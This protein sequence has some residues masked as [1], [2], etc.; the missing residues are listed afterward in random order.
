MRVLAEVE[1]RIPE[2]RGMLRMVAQM[3]P[4]A[5][6][7]AE[8]VACAATDSGSRVKAIQALAKRLAAAGFVPSETTD[9]RAPELA[10]G[11]GY[12]INPA[13]R[14][15]SA[16]SALRRLVEREEDVQNFA[17]T[18]L[19]GLARTAPESHPAPRGAL[20]ALL[21]GSAEDSELARS[22][23]ADFVLRAAP[24][25]EVEEVDEL[26]V[27]ELRTSAA[28]LRAQ[29]P[30]LAPAPQ[31]A[32]AHAGMT[33]TPASMTTPAG[34]I[35]G[36][37]ARSAPGG[38]VRALGMTFAVA[39]AAATIVG[40]V[41]LAFRHDPAPAAVATPAPT[42]P[43]APLVSAQVSPEPVPAPT[44]APEQTAKVEPVVPTPSAS[45]AVPALRAEPQSPVT[46]AKP[47]TTKAVEKSKPA[48][49]GSGLDEPTPKP[50]KGSG[51][52]F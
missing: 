39:A 43:V 42:T 3:A 27:A 9:V 5:A 26:S 50:K 20:L 35:A 28:E 52:A 13:D 41:A 2:Y 34:P 19:V 45:S 44:P 7:V 24:V 10:M 49:P 38:G 46:A 23:L 16:E 32:R 6:L 40:L 22:E 8:L 4:R 15:D 11:A 47:P 33:P 30:A 12:L 25:N 14:L 36:Q 31:P 1:G 29:R 21:L 48:L 51:V 17:C 18:I 37:S